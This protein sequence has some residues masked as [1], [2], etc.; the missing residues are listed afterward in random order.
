MKQRGITLFHLVASA[1]LFSIVLSLG[2][3]LLYSYMQMSRLHSASQSMTTALISARI[4]AVKKARPVVLCSSTDGAR[5]SG[6]NKWEDGFLYF[7][8]TDLNGRMNG[9]EKAEKFF[10]PLDNGATIRSDYPDSYQVVYLPSGRVKSTDNFNICITET[11]DSGRT[12]NINLT[13]RPNPKPGANQ[14]PGMPT[15]D[16]ER[17]LAQR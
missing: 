5:C 14:C 10:P 9:A 2:F 16:Q 3:P 7:V 8:D 6:E 15:A 11:T 13:G 17:M 12:I 1:A 4:T